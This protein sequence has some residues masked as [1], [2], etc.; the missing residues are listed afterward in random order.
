M[1]TGL[2][3]LRQVA[4]DPEDLEATVEQI[5]RALVVEVSFREVA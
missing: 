1:H 3:R 2:M 4:H 5:T